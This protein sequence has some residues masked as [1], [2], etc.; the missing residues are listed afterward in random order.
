MSEVGFI[1][2]TGAANRLESYVVGVQC[3][4]HVKMYDSK[5]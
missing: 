4:V 2:Q 3:I 1:D 5:L